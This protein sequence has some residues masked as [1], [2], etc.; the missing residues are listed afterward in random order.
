M[1]LSFSFLSPGLVGMT[2]N[3]SE[4]Q[5][6][7]EICQAPQTCVLDLS[8]EQR[9]PQQV[10]RL[11]LPTVYLEQNPSPSNNLDLSNQSISLTDTSLPLTTDIAMTNSRR[12]V[13]EPEKLADIPVYGYYLIG[14]LFFAI[15]ANLF[16]AMCVMGLGSKTPNATRDRRRGFI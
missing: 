12:Y 6:R 2:Q 10:T 14:I 1:S 13:Y 9:E 15:F 8:V 3:C 11:S 16:V 4:D 7:I 5:Q